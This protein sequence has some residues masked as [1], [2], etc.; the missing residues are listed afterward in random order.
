M[1]SVGGIA[2]WQSIRLQIERSPVQLRL[3]P[4]VLPL[5]HRKWSPYGQWQVKNDDT[6][7]MVFERQTWTA[8]NQAHSV[9]ILLKDPLKSERFWRGSN[10][11]PSACKADVITT[12]PQNQTVPVLDKNWIDIMHILLSFPGWIVLPFFVLMIA[13]TYCRIP[14]YCIILWCVFVFQRNDNKHN[15][16]DQSQVIVR[17]WVSVENIYFFIDRVA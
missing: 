17:E 12:T 4:T 7:E 6:F 1:S 15:Q 9:K 5:S 3:P 16:I 8:R 13:L 11:R 2:Q 14:W 10:S